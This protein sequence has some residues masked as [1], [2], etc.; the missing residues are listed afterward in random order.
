MSALAAA[1]GAVNLGQGFPDTR[2]RPRSSRPRAAIGTT[3]T[4]QYPPV[5]GPPG[6]APGDRRPPRS[7][8]RPRLDP[9]AEILVTAAPPRRCP[10][11][12]L[13]LLDTGDEVVLFE[14]MYDSYAAGI[15]MAGAWPRPCPP[16]ASR[17]R[18]PLTSTRRWRR[19]HAAHQALLL[20]TPHN[21]TGKVFTRDELTVH[22]R[23]GRASTT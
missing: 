9:E 5:P 1:T 22:R 19:D 15:A 2:A 10:A 7:A 6:A 20:N 12:L 23:A 21:P 14:P 17:R 16:P 18:L 11:A 4:D 13:A 8:S 3:A